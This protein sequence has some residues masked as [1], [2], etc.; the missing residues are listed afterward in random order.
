MALVGVISRSIGTYPGK[1]S[2]IASI[3]GFG[4][5][6]IQREIGENGVTLCT[7]L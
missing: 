3:P 7:I 2:I 4:L 6:F 5:D 1:I